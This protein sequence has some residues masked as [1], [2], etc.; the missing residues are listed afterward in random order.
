[1]YVDTS[2]FAKALL[3]EPGADFLAR[4]WA[5]AERLV[6]SRLIHV[7]TSSALARARREGRLSLAEVASAK[8]EAN[9][10]LAE[11]DLV[12]V[13]GPVVSSATELAEIHDLRA[14]D[15]VHL[16]SAVSLGDAELLVLTWD[17]A[18]A[19]AALAETLAVA[20]ES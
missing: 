5:R 12:E 14:Y 17:S 13:S 1:V 7:E 4:I 9:A 15:A 8:A 2:A 18:L 11:L 6:S 19:R 10:R 16:A 3:Q 20:P